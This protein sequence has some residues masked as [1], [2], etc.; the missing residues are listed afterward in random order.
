MAISHDVSKKPPPIVSLIP[1]L[2]QVFTRFFSCFG[3]NT[4]SNLFFSDKIIAKN[5]VFSK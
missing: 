4:L 1:P 2:F 5:S 3:R